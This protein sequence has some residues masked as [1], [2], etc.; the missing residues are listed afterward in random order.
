MS[1]ED[2]I[3]VAE[4]LRSTIDAMQIQF[5]NQVFHVT[6][7]F[8]LAACD[9]S[10]GNLDNLLANADQA[11]YLSK[12]AGRNCVSVFSNVPTDRIAIA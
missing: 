6:A 4:R 2:A 3:R 10:V 1:L 8:G 7:S 9:T 12:S 5:G 11:L